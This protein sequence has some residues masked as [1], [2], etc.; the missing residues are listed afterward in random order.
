MLKSFALV[1]FCTFFCT[2]LQADIQRKKPVV[3][4]TFDDGPSSDP[5]TDQILRVLKRHNA[6]ATF[7][8][9]GLRAQANPEKIRQIIDA[10]HALGNHTLSHGRLTNLFDHQVASELGAT[11]S[12]VLDAGAP[13]MSCFRPPFGSY[14]KSVVEIASRMGLHRVGWSIDTRDWDRNVTSEEIEIQL[15]DV[16]NDS[17]VLMHDGPRARWRS[18]DVF[19]RW[20][21]DMGHLYSFEVVPECALPNDAPMQLALAPPVI[22]GSTKPQDPEMT[23]PALLKKLRAYKIELRPEVVA[24]SDVSNSVVSN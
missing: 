1:L 10:G 4:L 11:N 19:T 23:I 16:Q 7:F 20:M 22:S 15:E 8:V 21:D 6:K 13:P 17:V 9:T 5:V 24:R 18:L 12:H 2:A 3:Y 14:N